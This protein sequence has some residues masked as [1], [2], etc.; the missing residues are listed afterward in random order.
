MAATK[1]SSKKGGAKK[2]GAKRGAAKK[3][4]AKSSGTRG[5]GSVLSNISSIAGTV[6]SAAGAI[7]GIASRKG[8]LRVATARDAGFNEIVAELRK[9]FKDAGHPG[10][11]SGFDRFVFE[12]IA[13]GGRR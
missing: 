11:R 3:G 12:D 2:G 9:R 6:G 7:G 8:E 13:A 10:C 5:L 4:G 1:R